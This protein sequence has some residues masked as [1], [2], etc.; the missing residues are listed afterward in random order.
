MFVTGDWCAW[1]ELIPLRRDPVTQ[2]F[3]LACSLA[4]RSA[5][6]QAQGCQKRALRE[7]TH[8]IRAYTAAGSDNQV[9]C[10]CVDAC[11]Y[12]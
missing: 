8:F 9:V 6:S 10:A 5:V 11:K 1:A 3:H 2:D 12:M 7:A 4:V